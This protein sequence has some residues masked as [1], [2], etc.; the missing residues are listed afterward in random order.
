MI[1]HKDLIKATWNEYG[2]SNENNARITASNLPKIGRC[3]RFVISD[4]SLLL[5]KSYLCENK[6]YYIYAG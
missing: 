3:T 6:I 4:H 1:H 5:P 2:V